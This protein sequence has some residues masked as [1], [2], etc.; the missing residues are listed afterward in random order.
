MVRR[1]QPHSDSGTWARLPPAWVCVP[2]LWGTDVSGETGGIGPGPVAELRAGYQCSLPGVG[3]CTIAMSDMNV[4]ES[5]T[6]AIAVLSSH[7]SGNP[8]MVSA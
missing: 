2:D 7:L 8:E 5:C 4:R 3:C 6:R 1:G